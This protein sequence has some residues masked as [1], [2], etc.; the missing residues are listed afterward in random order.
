MMR[1][2]GCALAGLFLLTTS[3]PAHAE[4]PTPPDPIGQA[5]W[6]KPEPVG[7]TKTIRLQWGPYVVHP[8]TDLWRPHTARI[9]ADGFITGL[10]PSARLADGNQPPGSQFHIHHGGWSFYKPPAHQEI[11]R[12][13]ERGYQLFATGEEETHIDLARVARADPRYA[14]GLRYGID[15]YQSQ[16]ESLYGFSM[17]HNKSTQ[18]FTV[19]LQLEIDFVYGTQDAIKA[20][21]GLD[22]HPVGFTLVGWVF[23]VPRFGRPYAFPRDL[24]G[25]PPAVSVAPGVGQIWTAPWDGTLVLG[26]GHLHPGGVEVVVSNLGRAEHPCSD[27]GDA[28]PGTTVARIRAHTRSGTYPSEE[29]QVGVTKPGWRLKVRKGDR[30]AINGVYEATDY[31]YMDAMSHFGFWADRSDPPTAGEDTCSAVLVDDPVAEGAAVLESIPNRPWHGAAQLLCTAC[32]NLAAPPPPLGQHLN[33]VN[34]AAFEYA[35]GDQATMEVTGAPW[36][37]RGE[38]ITFVN[39]DWGALIRHTATSC[40]APCNGPSM[41]NYPNWDGTFDSGVLGSAVVPGFASGTEGFISARYQP[42]GSVDTSSLR[43]GL[44]SYYCRLHAWMRGSFY[45]VA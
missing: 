11:P 42:V 22:Y 7:T 44:H 27:D 18:T 20:A 3:T 6:A 4:D 15:A 38:V 14:E 26:A 43:E 1:R 23:H 17:L 36:V 16:D 9:G 32:D 33:V 39:Q 45:V 13:A 12:E 8:G 34:I 29:F 28:F 41:A 10:R 31:G 40:R 21:T 25:P 35:P 30:L 19:W 2:L 5:A 24:Q 37:R